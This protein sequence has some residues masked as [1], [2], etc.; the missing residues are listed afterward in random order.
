[1]TIRLV[2]DKA[3]I[4]IKLIPVPLMFINE[5]VCGVYGFQRNFQI[6][7]IIITIRPVRDKVQILIKSVA[8]PLTSINGDKFEVYEF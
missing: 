4:L 7:K 6:F 2:R 8:V 3:Q 5:V 1:M